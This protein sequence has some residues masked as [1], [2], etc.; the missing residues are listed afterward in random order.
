MKKIINCFI[1]L[2]LIQISVV[3]QIY[4]YRT[5]R[6][7]IKSEGEK[8]GEWHDSDALLVMDLDDKQRLTIYS[9]MVQ[10]YDIIEMSKKYSDK[11]GD[12]N[13]NF[14]CVDQDGV[15]CFVTHCF[16]ES[17]KG[18]EQIYIRYN[19]VTWAYY[20]RRLD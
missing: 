4:K 17:Q 2:F 12:T 20:L 1:F 13:F 11:D 19:N 18:K 6:V 5:T 15:S 16:C 3:A 14:S 10:K 8:W 9:K 7:A